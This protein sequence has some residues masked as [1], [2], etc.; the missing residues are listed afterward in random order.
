MIQTVEPGIPVPERY[1][2]Y[3]QSMIDV[4]RVAVAANG[5]ADPFIV[6]G[7][8]TDE[9]TC[10]VLGITELPFELGCA[11]VTETARKIN[12]EFV[13]ISRTLIGANAK[14]REEAEAMA[15]K[16]KRPEDCPNA[17]TVAFV[18]L[19]T[20]HGVWVA[21]KPVEVVDGV[22][23]I[24]DMELSSCDPLMSTLNLLPPRTPLQ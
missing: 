23:T 8:L 17:Q 3:V 7:N 19:E 12:A 18:S 24:G 10:P 5:K 20:Y 22:S 6:L 21:V 16:Y 14:T 9:W 4:L 15:A 13:M 2:A 11:A 1:T